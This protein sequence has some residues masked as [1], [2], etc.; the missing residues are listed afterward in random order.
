VWKHSQQRLPNE[1]IKDDHG[2]E[3]FYYNNCEWKGSSG[4]ATAHL[5][6]HSIFVRRYSATPS[7]IAQA[8]N[9]QQGLHNM[10]A[11]KAEFKNNKTVTILRNA[12]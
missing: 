2:H 3:I 12:A 8:N 4:N 6:K 9:L 10:A 1:P 11:K 7:T 5:Q